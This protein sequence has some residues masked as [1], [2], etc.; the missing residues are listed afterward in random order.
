[1]VAWLQ[2]Q[3]R[4]RRRAP[5]TEPVWPPSTGG[6]RTIPRNTCG[7]KQRPY[8][9][10]GEPLGCQKSRTAPIDPVKRAL[11]PTPSRGRGTGVRSGRSER[12]EPSRPVSAIDITLRMTPYEVMKGPNVGA[13]RRRRYG[14]RE[15]IRTPW[16]PRTPPMASGQCICVLW[17]F[18][19]VTCLCKPP[20]PSHCSDSVWAELRDKWASADGRR[21]G[22]PF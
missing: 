16:A 22:S 18:R 9:Q 14:R 12:A 8:P 5:E 4:Q 1:M 13:K 11:A 20:V 19:I 7:G 10:D 6:M 21:L 3:V 2:R 17:P 15:P